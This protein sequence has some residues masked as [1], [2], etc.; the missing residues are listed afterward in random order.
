VAR[1]LKAEDIAAHLAA[2]P[3]WR[4]DG[5]AIRRE[6]AFPDFAAAIG[7]V[8]RVAEAAEEADH[9]PDI[10]IRYDR[11]TLVLSTHS[12]GGLTAKD[13]DL[14]ARADALASG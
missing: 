12:A 8:R 13:F 4:R 2:L 6:Y 1:R 11:V 5:D 14:A 3:D 7:F 10:D 9:H